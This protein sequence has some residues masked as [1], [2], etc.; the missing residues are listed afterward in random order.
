[1]DTVWPGPREFGCPAEE[2]FSIMEE[3]YRGIK[4]G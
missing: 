4:P 2:P 3:F 1:M